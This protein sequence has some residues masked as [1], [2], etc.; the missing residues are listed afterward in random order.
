M[1]TIFSGDPFQEQINPATK[2]VQVIFM[3]RSKGLTKD[4]RL[5]MD[6]AILELIMAFL[7]SNE[8]NMDKLGTQIS[9]DCN[10]DGTK[11]AKAQNLLHLSSLISLGYYKH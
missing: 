5:T 2:N 4:K 7:G 8:S 6:K 1:S 9:V 3:E 11:H 10:A